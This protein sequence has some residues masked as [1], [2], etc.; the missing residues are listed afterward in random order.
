MEPLNNGH[1]GDKHFVHC[2]EV[3][4]YRQLM[5]GGQAVCPLLGGC[6]L[7][8]VSIIRGFTVYVCIYL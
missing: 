8:G 6:P 2:S 4:M 3:E 1:G 7:I 5:A